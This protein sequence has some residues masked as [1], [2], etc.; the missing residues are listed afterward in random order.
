MEITEICQK[1]EAFFREKNFGRLLGYV[2]TGFIRG[3][4]REILDRFTFH[5]QCIDPQVASTRRSVLGLPLIGL[6]GG[7]EPRRCRKVR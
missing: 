3:N 1:G 5:Q 7:V 6:Q 4:D 2:E